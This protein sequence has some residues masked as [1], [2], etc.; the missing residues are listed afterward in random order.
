MRRLALVASLVLALGIAAGAQQSPAPPSEFATTA[1]ES[2]IELLRQQAG[3]PGISG[4]LIQDG[5]IVWERGLGMANLEA[6][7]RATPDTPYP[8]AD[9]SQI[10]AA[11]LLLECV[12]LRRLD[13][14][15]PLSG[16]GVV[17][18]DAGATLRQVLS[19]GAPPG[20]ATSFAYDPS[21]FA[22]LTAAMEHC[23]R[24]PYRRSIV[25]RLLD[26]VAMFDSV[27]GRDLQTPNVVPVDLLEPAALARY[28]RVLE[29]MAVPYRIDSRRRATRTEL[30]LEGINAATGLVSTVRDLARFDAAL[31][32]G[33]LL[34][35]ETVIAAWSPAVPASGLAHPMGSGWFVQSYR[36]TPVI[37]HFGVIPNAY[38]A[39]IVKVPSRGATMILLANSDGLTG[40]FQLAAGDVTRSIFASVFLRM[41]L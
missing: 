39:L 23:V 21:R 14:D 28:G 22:A 37:W 4:A 35:R 33:A 27:P 25:H 7:I 10:F 5:I 34:Q 19:H 17:L 29:R 8:V 20:S 31:D 38:S 16:Y 6:R 40:P 18:P 13:L 26:R 15:A 3:I 2:Y 24:Q 41:L 9:L 36:G 32:A 12:E 30:P 1:F 11:V